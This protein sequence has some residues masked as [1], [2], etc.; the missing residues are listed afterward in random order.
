MT[1]QGTLHTPRQTI[2]LRSIL[3]LLSILVLS[4]QSSAQFNPYAKQKKKRNQVPSYFGLQ[5]K[6]IIPVRI[7]GAG[8][9]TLSN[10]ILE[11]TVTPLW[12]YSFGGVVRA[13]I[14]ERFAIETGLNIVRRNYR[15]DYLIPDSSFTA[16]TTLGVVSYDIPINFLVYIQLSKQWYMNTSMGVSGNFY[17]TNVRSDDNGYPHM[18]MTEGR[19][20]SWIRLAFNAN[21]GFEW[22]TEKAGFFYLGGSFQLPFGGIFDIAPAYKYKN[23]NYPILGEMNGT[24]VTVDFKYFLPVIDRKG[25][26]FLKGPVEQ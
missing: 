3:P 2:T 13:G 1:K 6:P 19:R 26:Q 10:D 23:T 21:V 16:Q 25:K 7:F 15:T 20:K 22:R 24:Y 18:F 9:M 4:F 5:A 8:P 17:P 14:S 11:A 12:G